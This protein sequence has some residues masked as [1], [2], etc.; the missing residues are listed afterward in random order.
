MQKLSSFGDIRQTGF[1]VH[2][3]G[4][5]ESL[6]H[7]PSK[8]FLDIPYPPTRPTLP[9]CTECNNQ[10]SSD[11][12][13]LACFIECVICGTT[14]PASLGREKI[15]KALRRNN[16][17]RQLIETS[18]IQTEPGEDAPLVWMPDEARVQQV[19]LKLARCHAA[20]ELNEPQLSA[21]DHLSILPL[22]TLSEAQREHF[23]TPPDSSVWPEVGSRAM[24][25]LLIADE[26]Y[27]MGWITVQ[28]G[29]YR[30]M[31][32][33]AEAVMIRGVL[34]EYLGYEVIW[35]N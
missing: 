12:E 27:S 5:T 24:Q 19:V 30:Y 18:R 25:R 35:E 26:A 33:G 31:A 7:A 10:L 17:L 20:Y 2:C 1:C 16:K 28:E 32:I 22:P 23:E 14:E 4:S 21:P 15:A 3:G 29:R 8:V 13:Y 11:E 34:S 9:S 6:D